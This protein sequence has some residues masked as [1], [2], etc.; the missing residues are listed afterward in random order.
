MSK[1]TLLISHQMSHSAFISPKR[2]IFA[3]KFCWIEKM[4]HQ[5]FLW[6]EP[7]ETLSIFILIHQRNQPKEKVNSTNHVRVFV[8]D[9]WT[10][11]TDCWD[12][13]DGQ[14]FKSKLGF[15]HAKIYKFQIAANI[16]WKN[17]DGF[18]FRW[19]NIRLSRS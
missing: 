14:F 16:W 10:V 2:I 6:I 8:R 12:A 18:H 13:T 17:L 1:S 7:F 11:R 5:I 4:S 19:L 15:P 9:Q 3:P